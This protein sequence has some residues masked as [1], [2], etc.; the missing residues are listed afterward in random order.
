MKHQ[1]VTIKVWVETRKALRLIAA[2]SDETIVEAIHRLALA[3]IE[4]IKE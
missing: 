4:R 3:E 1:F 2:L